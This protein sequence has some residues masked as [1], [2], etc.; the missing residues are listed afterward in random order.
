MKVLFKGD[1]LLCIILLVPLSLHLCNHLVHQR[2][3]SNILR[4]PKHCYG[5]RR[6]K[7]LHRNT[8]TQ[9]QRPLR[10]EGLSGSSHRSAT[11]QKGC[12]CQCHHQQSRHFKTLVHTLLVPEVGWENGCPGKKIQ[13]GKCR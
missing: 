7:Y 6:Y 8:H 1:L 11:R 13:A 10:N 12:Y 9:Q 3:W 2:F 5:N 4:Q